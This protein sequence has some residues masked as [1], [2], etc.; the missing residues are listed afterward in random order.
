VTE[1]VN[2]GGAGNDGQTLG[3]LIQALRGNAAL[4]VVVTVSLVALALTSLYAKPPTYVARSQVLV[5]ASPASALADPVKRQRQTTVDTEADRAYSDAVLDDV[6]RATDTPD[7]RKALRVSALPVSRV[8]VLEY[9][10]ADREGAEIGVRAWTDSYIREQSEFV[11]QIGADVVD[12]LDNVPMDQIAARATAL[13]DGDPGLAWRQ[14]VARHAQREFRMRDF[15]ANRASVVRQGA[16]VAERKPWG[17]WAASALVLGV[18]ITGAFVRWRRSRGVDDAPE[19]R[20]PGAVD[21]ERH[22]AQVLRGAGSG[23]PGRPAAGAEAEL[24][25]AGR[26]AAS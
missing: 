11:E 16:A 9:R 1:E 24:A 15:S 18:L 26:A 2:A 4:L 19:L 7:P 22:Q 12:S 10:G 3:D 21:N 25:A 14:N 5:P 13:A 6:A 17:T 23:T 8:L 20:D